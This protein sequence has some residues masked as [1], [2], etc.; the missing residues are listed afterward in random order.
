MLRLDLHEGKDKCKGTIYISDNLNEDIY[1]NGK[2]SLSDFENHN[3]YF[4]I[5]KIDKM[6]KNYTLFSSKDGND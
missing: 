2:I 4:D 6:L 3:I 5:N 1:M